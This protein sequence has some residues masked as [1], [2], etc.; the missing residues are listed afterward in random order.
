MQLNSFA[1][2][3]ALFLTAVGAVPLSTRSSDG[4]LFTETA[5]SSINDCGDSTF[6]DES[7][8]G[9]PL[10]ADCQQIAA[11]IAGGG[12]WV[13][14]AEGVQRELVSYG[15]CAF[16]VTGVGE[17]TYDVGNQDIIDLINSSIADLYV[18]FTSVSLSL[19]WLSWRLK[20]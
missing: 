10:I 3:L 20:C 14:N 15:T 8:G 11:N 18:I 12:T 17:L 1:S 6:V 16:G 13:T 7:S 5:D 19:F 2:R 4:V 9:S